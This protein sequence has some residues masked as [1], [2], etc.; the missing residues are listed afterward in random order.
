MVT[1]KK[2]K[3]IKFEQTSNYI[4][5]KF[6]SLM[7]YL[8]NR[9]LEYIKDAIKHNHF[10]QRNTDKGNYTAI[11]NYYNRF[12]MWGT[13]D[14]DKG[15]YELVD[16]NAKAL[17]EHREDF[18]WLYNRLGDYRSKKILTSILYYWLT[19][20]YHNIEDLQD[21]V[22]SQYFDLDIIGCDK[23]EVF[24][25]IGAYMGETTMKYSEIFGADCY[26]NI[27]CY[28]IVPINI[29]NTNINIELSKLKNVIVR[30]KGV[31]DKAGSLFL[32]NGEFTS[33]SKLSEQGE[34]EIE[35]VTI[36]N[37]VEG[38]VTF[39][40]MDIEGGEEN[41][42]LG[43][44]NKILE[45]HPKLALSVYHNNN[46]LWKLARIIYEIDPTYKF[47]LRYYGNPLLPTEY[48]LYAV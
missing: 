24:V 47:Y 5:N 4:D 10:Y 28:D 1:R 12:K 17:V 15:D 42:L 34:T 33:T 18:E 3:N 39:I 43:C 26:K 13:I 23:N 38:P 7:D 6:A 25:D 14:L 35:T 19:V 20:D 40:K 45:N 48:L 21:K 32:S 8:R 41:A 11:V 27:Y 9:S 44:R 2:Q 29:K 36:D 22:Y 16:S 46:H 31:S 30:E 37:D